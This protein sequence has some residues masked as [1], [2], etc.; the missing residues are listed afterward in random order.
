MNRLA[1][2][3]NDLDD[4][5]ARIFVRE[6]HRIG[7][8]DQAMKHLDPANVLRRGY[9]ITRHKGKVLKNASVLKKWAVIE[10]KLCSGDVTSIV[11]DRKETGKSEQRQ[12]DILLPGLE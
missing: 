11:Q 12:T 9:S 1:I 10:T 8:M 7:A 4:R 3:R 6:E 2:I 5:V